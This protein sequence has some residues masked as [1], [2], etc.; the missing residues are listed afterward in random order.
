MSDISAPSADKNDSN[1]GNGDAK[2][3]RGSGQ[4]RRK[5]RPFLKGRQVKPIALE[6]V[7]NVLGKRPRKRELLIEHLHL[8]QDKF[9]H[10]STAHLAALAHEMKMAMA[11]VYEVATFYAHFDVIKE[12]DCP[13]PPITVRVCDSLTCS[14]FGAEGILEELDQKIGTDVR[15]VRAPCI[16][17]CDKAPV[18]AIGHNLIENISTKKLEKYATKE[19]IPHRKIN[20]IKLDPYIESGGYTLL[21]ECLS[22]SRDQQAFIKELEESALRGLGGAGFPTARKWNLVRE[23]NGKKV[24]AVNGDEGEPGTFKDRLYLESDPHRIL[25]GMLIAAWAVG[26]EDCYFYLRDEYPE[27][28]KLLEEEISGLETEGLVGHTRIHLRR[29]A[30]AYICGEESAMIESIEGKRGYPRHRPPYVAEVGVFNRP[31]LVNNIETLFW[32]RDIIE[33]G[34]TWYNDQGTVEHPGFRSYS[35]SGRVKNPGV[36]LAPAGVTAQELVD[37]Y[38]GGMSEGHRFH[39]YL[40]GGASGGI[41]PAHMGNLRLDF[42]QLE[43]YGCFVGSHAVVILS[44]KDSVKD[45]ALNLLRF[46]EDESCGQCSPCRVGTEKAV[47]LMKKEEWDKPLLTEL[48]TTMRDASICGLGQAASNP[49]TAV[50]RFFPNEV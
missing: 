50:L 2:F 40:P 37:D 4:G 41:L 18:A 25:E 27:I 8:F 24:V 39:A 6:E 14:L 46:F 20:P 26:A 32:I 10:L 19:K 17:A 13:P 35:V 5:G 43:K 49:L 22:G 12:N 48:A 34:P 45:A 29:G 3:Q 47:T 23:N 44:D 15:V 11:E 28:R 36:K 21:K 38:C 1:R 31:T 42:G 16:G 9:G 30:G 33:K 7:K